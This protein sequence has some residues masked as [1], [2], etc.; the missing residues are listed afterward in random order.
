MLNLHA[1]CLDRLREITAAALPHV[2]V[3][4]NKFITPD[5]Y[6]L[7]SAGDEAL[8]KEVVARLQNSARTTAADY[9]G[10]ARPTC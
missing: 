7:F 6:D 5:S 1:N 8:P 3:E 4:N 10:P 2:Q 9:G